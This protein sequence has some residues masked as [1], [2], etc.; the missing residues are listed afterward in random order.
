MGRD[1]LVAPKANP[2]KTTPLPKLDR[3]QRELHTLTHNFTH[4]LRKDT[5][6]KDYAST[7]TK[8]NSGFGWVFTLFFELTHI[9]TFL[10][11]TIICITG[12]FYKVFF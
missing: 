1:L 8:T 9:F 3:I 12:L 11:P 2:G 4:T 10:I 6:S 5:D 7:I